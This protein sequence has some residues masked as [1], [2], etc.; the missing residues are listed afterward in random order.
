MRDQTLCI[1]SIKIL[2]FVKSTGFTWIQAPLAILAKRERERLQH[3]EGSLHRLPGLPALVEVAQRAMAELGD[4]ARQLLARVALDHTR[5]DPALLARDVV[6]LAQEDRL[7]DARDPVEDHAASVD[8]FP[9]PAQGQSQ[10]D[11]RPR[12]QPPKIRPNR[13][14]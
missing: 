9:Q 4:D 10:T 14:V 3:A 1:K 2:D 12:A 6:K 7:P 11:S 8:A 13:P 5:G